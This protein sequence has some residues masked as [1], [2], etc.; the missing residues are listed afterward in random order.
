MTSLIDILNDIPIEE[1]QFLLYKCH[2]KMF[3]DLAVKTQKVCKDGFGKSSKQFEQ[4]ILTKYNLPSLPGSNLL[5]Q[6]IQNKNM[7]GNNDP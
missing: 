4:F 6:V 5:L 3:E 2:S 1:L 7:R